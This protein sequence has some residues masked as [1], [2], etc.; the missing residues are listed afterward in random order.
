MT[1]RVLSI[2][3]YL[4]S[5]R[6]STGSSEPIHFRILTFQDPDLWI[7]CYLDPQ[8]TSIKGP[9]VPV[10]WYLGCLKGCLGVLV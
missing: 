6:V 3:W 5:C 9:V 2:F 10:R 7:S 8:G 4:R 1:P